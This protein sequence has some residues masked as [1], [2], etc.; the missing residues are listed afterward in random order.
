MHKA[1]TA[2][3]ISRGPRKKAGQEHRSTA[4]TPLS[5]RRHTPQS[6]ISLTGH[7]VPRA[8]CCDGALGSRRTGQFALREPASEA[9]QNKGGNE[10]KACGCEKRAPKTCSEKNRDPRKARS[11]SWLR[12][13]AQVN[14]PKPK[15]RRVETCGAGGS[16][17]SI[18]SQTNSSF[19]CST[20]KNV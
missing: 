2:P 4:K 13:R 10:P 14:P 20:I 5:R 17:R 9:K 12:G 8:W 11:S 6:Q 1:A 16:P 3:T 15:T 18:A 7:F 19:C